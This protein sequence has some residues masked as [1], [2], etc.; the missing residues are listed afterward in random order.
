MKTHRELVD[1]YLDASWALAMERVAIRQG[2]L[3]GALEE[4]LARDPDAAVPRRTVKRCRAAIR[5]AFA[6]PA[7]RVK[8]VLTRVL[9]AAALC[10]LLTT[11]ACAVS[12]R[13]K[14]FL[15]HIFYSVAET[16]TAFTLQDP[17]IEDVGALQG[18]AQEFNGLRFEWLPEGY[19]YVYVSPE[20]D[21]FFIFDTTQKPLS[22]K[23]LPPK[24]IYVTQDRLLMAGGRYAGSVPLAGML[25]RY[26]DF[27]VTDGER[28]RGQL[29]RLITYLHRSFP[30]A[31]FAVLGAMFSTVFCL[32]A[33][34]FAVLSFF[35]T[36]FF[37]L[38]MPFDMRLRLGALSFLPFAVI[39]S[40]ALFLGMNLTFMTASIVTVIYMFC[41][42]TEYSRALSQKK[43]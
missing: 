11:A 4:Q 6:P 10:G 18:E 27:S 5:R 21:F 43:G 26:G 15:T 29:S 3:A 13:F 33:F 17:Q 42:L 41:F 30:V 9:I 37:R 2:E 28:V 25:E 35:I 24:G 40:V 20:K 16:F 39:N 14:A 1:G 38:D 7:R 23:D 22:F 31:V 34:F 36:P 19:E 12:P 32:C 8:T